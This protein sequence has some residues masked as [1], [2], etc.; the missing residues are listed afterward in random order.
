ME[1]NEV[2]VSFAITTHNETECLKK[3][4]DQ[5]FS[6][7]T[8]LDEIVIVDDNST[9][10]ETVKILA[11]AVENHA[12]VFYHSLNGD[13]AAHK[14]YLTDSCKNEYIFAIDADE[15]LD[16]NLAK[17]FREILAINQEVEMFRLPRIN[18]VEGLTLNH[19]NQWRWQIS[20]QPTEIE[21]KFMSYDSDEFKLVKA[22]NLIL[23]DTNGMIKYHVPLINW[24]DY[25]G[26]IYKKSDTIK[27][28]NKV[29]ETLVG[30]KKYATF[31][32]ARQF[33]LLHYK[34][35][36]TQEKQNQFYSTIR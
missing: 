11:W 22:F 2:K 21:E 35:I 12:R 18:T 29:H 1:P 23:N 33:S 5:I 20:A 8:V 3:L 9:D 32:T 28:Q 17:K 34:S 26:R 36:Q 27:W 7:K 13:F 10:P 31:P 19:V 24:P 15:L 4:L 25:Q 14:N 6:I 16:D 30:F